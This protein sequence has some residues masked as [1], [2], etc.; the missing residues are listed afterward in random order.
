MKKCS[1]TQ[2]RASGLGFYSIVF[3]LLLNGC[4][5]LRF[6]PNERQKQNAWLHNRT[7]LAAAQTAKVQAAS[8][9]LQDLT[10]LSEL[11]SRAFTTYFGLPK[12]FPAAQTSD[13]ILAES[14]R[15]LAKDAI[16]DSA[17]R[18]DPWQTADAAMEFGIGIFALLGGVYGAKAAKFLTDAKARSKALREIITGNE[19]FKKTNQTQVE[20]FKQAHAGQSSQTRQ[21]VTEVKGRG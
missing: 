16:A 5:S 19:L 1:Q 3:V 13:D 6:A 9:E 18:P 21:I 15:Q 10:E 20:P 11:Q 8:G 17:A 12:E 7:A 14:S 4:E 2:R